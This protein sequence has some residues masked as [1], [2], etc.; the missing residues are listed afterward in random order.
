[1]AQV[2]PEL[3]ASMPGQCLVRLANPSTQTYADVA[4]EQMRKHP[5][6]VEKK[7]HGYKLFQF[8]EDQ[9]YEVRMPGRRPGWA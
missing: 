3:A 1:M 2:Q 8:F 9:Q 5:V 7:A 4:S 6:T